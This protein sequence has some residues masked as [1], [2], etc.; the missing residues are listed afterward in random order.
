MSKSFKIFT[1]ILVVALVI[2]NLYVLP[3]GNKEKLSK[4]SN[5]IEEAK[6]EEKEGKG[7]ALIG[8]DFELINQNGDIYNSNQMNGKYSLVYFG[9]TNCPMV[10]P[11]ALNT[12]TLALNELG[13]DAEKFNT[14]FI[15]TDPERD[16]VERYQEY[17]SAFHPS[18]IWLTGTKE[19]LQKSYDAYRVYAKKINAEDGSNNYDMNHS[20]IIYVMDK[21]GEYLKHYNHKTEID[22]VISGLKEL[23]ENS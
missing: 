17:L 20:S 16:T 1:I 15:T 14:I 22:K 8:G 2:I 6:S 10:C 9:F 13:E 18:I 3:E 4:A 7:K 23:V 21:N 11:T 19:Q 12:L 5:D